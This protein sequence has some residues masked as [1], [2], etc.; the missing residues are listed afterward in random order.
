MLAKQDAAKQLAE[1]NLFHY[2]LVTKDDFATFLDTK[3]GWQN[4]VGP[5]SQPEF[6]LIT[7]VDVA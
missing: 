7:N 3:T 1:G 5:I 6:E 2:A 4:Y